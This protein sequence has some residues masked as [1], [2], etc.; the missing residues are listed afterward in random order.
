MTDGNLHKLATRLGEKLL[1][2]EH[3]LALAESCT[4]GWIGQVLTGVPGSSRWFE[5]GFVTYSNLA[6]S[7]MLGVP[8]QIIHEQG[9][10][11]R[12]VV[13]HM[14]TGAVANSAAHWSIAVSGV[15]GPDGGSA[16]RPV[17][18][19]W[20]AWAGPD[21]WLDSQVFHFTGDREAVRRASVQAGLQGLLD[22]LQ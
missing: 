15:A 1:A 22:C 18:T 9:A 8:A 14:A 6:K 16:A 7:Q 20:I 12:F 19:V 3:M 2:R 10:V 17:G 21:G 5:R 4:G 13:E 11:S